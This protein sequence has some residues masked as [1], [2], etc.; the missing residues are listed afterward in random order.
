MS[1][2]I[3]SDL[4]ESYLK[5]RYKG[6][7]KTMGEKGLSHDYE[8]LMK[9]TQ[10]R[11]RQTATARLLARHDGDEVPIR[12]FLTADLLKRGLAVASGYRP[13][14]RGPLHPLRRPAA[15]GW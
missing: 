7:L 5:C 11:I 15:G 13:R 8:I 1:G 6:H 10:A 9:E 2:K 14:R 3:T 4:L 12:L